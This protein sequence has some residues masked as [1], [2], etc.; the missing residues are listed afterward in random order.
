MPTGLVGDGASEQ[1]Y[2]NMESPDWKMDICRQYFQLPEV[3]EIWYCYHS[4]MTPQK[5]GQIL[6]CGGSNT[7]ADNATTVVELLT[8]K[9]TPITLRLLFKQ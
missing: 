8:P 7:P 5:T 4:I 6:V 2:K 1:D 9:P 3:M